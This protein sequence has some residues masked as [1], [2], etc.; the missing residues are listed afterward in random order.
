MVVEAPSTDRCVPYRTINPGDLAQVG[1]AEP[2]MIEQ[3]FIR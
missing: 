3:K 1:Q 2:R